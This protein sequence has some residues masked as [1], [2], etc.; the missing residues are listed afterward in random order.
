MLQWLATLVKQGYV[1]PLHKL[2]GSEEEREETGE[3]CVCRTDV[4][5]TGKFSVSHWFIFRYRHNYWLKTY[6]LMKKS[7]EMEVRIVYLLTS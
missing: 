7:F 1:D 5:R 4:G 3:V 6:Q 2:Q